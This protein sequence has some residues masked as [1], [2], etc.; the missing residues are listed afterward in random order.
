MFC[1]FSYSRI[2]TN[3]KGKLILKPILVSYMFLET[4]P[5]PLGCRISS[6]YIMVHSFLLCCFCISV[7][8]VVMSPFSFL[9]LF[10][11]VLFSFWW[12]WIAVSQSCVLYMDI[13]VTVSSC[14]NPFIFIEP[15]SLCFVIVFALN[16]ISSQRSID[17]P[18]FFTFL[19]AWTIFI[20]SLI[21]MCVSFLKCLL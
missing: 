13:S 11:Y 7:L 19:F 6:M 17:G 20:H 16:S 1:I 14:V 5:F 21:S 10:I 3:K 9:I 2:L 8:S 15:L 12:A 4:C 18:T